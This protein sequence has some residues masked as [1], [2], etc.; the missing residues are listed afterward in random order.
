LN[1]DALCAEAR[2]RTGLVDFG[3]PAIDNALSALTN[4]LEHHADLHPLGRFLV[5]SHLRDL[6][7]TRLRLA[8][9]WKVRLDRLDASPLRQPIFIMG[10]PRSGSTFLHELLAQDPE[11]RS[12]QVWEVMFPLPPGSEAQRARKAAARLWWFRRL[13]PKAD[14]VHPIRAHSPHECVA[15]QTY[16]LLS[17]EFVTTCRL[18]DYRAF[19]NASDLRPA[20]AWEK[21]FLQHLQSGR[22][23][24]RWLLKSPDHVH[25]LE[26]LFS[27]FPDALVIQT[28]R[29]PLE[30]LRS[31][32][33]LTEVLQG[34]FVRP[35]NRDR[36][37]EREADALSADME[38]FISFRDAHS[39]LA[40][41]FVDVNYNELVAD[42]LAVVR[43]IYQHFEVPL[44]ETA[45]ERMRKLALQRSRYSGGR[46]ALTLADMGV[47]VAVQAN[48]FK[49][50]CRRFGIP[51]PQAEAG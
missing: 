15:I 1:S 51:F 27:V 35:D 8:D 38:R 48:R 34:L 16:T 47:D 9:A 41:R 7:E 30:V 28:H 18:E 13:A 5:R 6:L 10:M 12:P 39:H 32:I 14:A 43:R 42:P 46:T 4:S 22:P 23:E 19:L 50:Y 31:L 25:G 21:R 20:Y 36:Q 40:R 33:Q 26:A 29:N 3:E 45:T 44:S 49:D 37:A 17:Q 24:K 2:K 11:L